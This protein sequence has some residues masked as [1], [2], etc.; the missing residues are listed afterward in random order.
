MYILLFIKAENNL[1]YTPM[2]DSMLAFM[3]STL[4]ASCLG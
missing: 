2:Q 1:Y 3:N 4:A